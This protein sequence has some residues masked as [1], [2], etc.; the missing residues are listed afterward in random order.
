[1]EALTVG[2]AA[3]AT[4]WSAR[5]L[6]YLERT[7]LVDRRQPETDRAG[8]RFSLLLAVTFLVS[9]PVAFLSTVAAHLMWLGTVLL[10]YPLRR[11][12]HYAR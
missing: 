1:M 6:R 8:D 4:G 9:V 12:T 10:R 2:E 3:T 7:G 5:M 11:L